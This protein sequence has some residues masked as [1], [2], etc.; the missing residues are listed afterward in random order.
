MDTMVWS[1]GHERCLD[2]YTVVHKKGYYGNTARDTNK[3]DPHRYGED[4]IHFSTIISPVLL[5][6]YLKFTNAFLK[7]TISNKYWILNKL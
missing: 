5:L 3:N 1:F 2:L 4:T 7:D 6:M